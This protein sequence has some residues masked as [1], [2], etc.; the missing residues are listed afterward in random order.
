MGKKYRAYSCLTQNQN[1]TAKSFSSMW[2]FSDCR[3]QEFSALLQKH[4]TR[5]FLVLL[6]HA[7]NCSL[8]KQM[9]IKCHQISECQEITQ[10]G[11]CF[12]VVCFCILPFPPLGNCF[13]SGTLTKT[14]FCTMLSAFLILQVQEQALLLEQDCCHSSARTSPASP[15]SPGLGS[16]SLLSGFA[17]G[18][19]YTFSSVCVF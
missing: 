13:L 19:M 18:S 1:R 14:S 3:T 7:T 15:S 8:T 4:S 17:F 12:L 16:Q 10:K 9:C 5:S 2:T 11:L 6:Q